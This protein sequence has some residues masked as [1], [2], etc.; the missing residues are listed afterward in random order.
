MKLELIK[1]LE[2]VASLLNECSNSDK[3][4]WFFEKINAIK[5]LEENNGDFK[6]VISEIDENLVGMGS[7]S[8]IS[9]RPRKG[10]KLSYRDAAE[11]QWVLVD[12]IGTLIKD[13]KV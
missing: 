9:L 5:N 7:L 11:K 10:S 6:S 13:C 1:A 4:V 3:A 2:E 8:D 12:K